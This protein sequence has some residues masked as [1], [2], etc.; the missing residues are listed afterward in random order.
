MDTLKIQTTLRGYNA[1][2]VQRLVEIKHEPLA[3]VASYLF[4]RWIDDNETFLAKYGL[5]TAH[6]H[7]EEERREKVTEIGRIKKGE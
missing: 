7:D 5:T 2:V 4:T 6:F 1:W 3:D